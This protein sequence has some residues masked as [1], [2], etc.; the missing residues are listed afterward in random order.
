[1]KLQT[2]SNANTTLSANLLQLVV[3]TSNQATALKIKSQGA[4]KGLDIQQT[5]NQQAF[6]IDSSAA[7]NPTARIVNAGN[8]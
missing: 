1:M 3:G 4:G 8:I 7:T 2:S 6:N 5:G